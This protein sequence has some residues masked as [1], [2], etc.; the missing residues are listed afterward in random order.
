MLIKYIYIYT[1]LYIYNT[2]IYCYFN[3]INLDFKHL[4]QVKYTIGKNWKNSWS[5][6]FFD[7]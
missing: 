3:N 6:H 7:C 4:V 5:F 2:N 1:K